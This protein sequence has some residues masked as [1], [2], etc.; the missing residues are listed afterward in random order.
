MGA[1]E[2]SF[3]SRANEDEPRSSCAQTGREN[4]DYVQDVRARVR[5]TRV[6]PGIA[7]TQQREGYR[8]TIQ[9]FAGHPGHG[10]SADDSEYASPFHDR[11]MVGI[12]GGALH[13]WQL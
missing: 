12:L 10:V 9:F 5:T 11:P 7:T 2:R 6:E 4:D 3:R 13:E 1:E 8:R